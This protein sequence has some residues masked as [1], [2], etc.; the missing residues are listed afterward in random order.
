MSKEYLR[1]FEAQKKETDLRVNTDIERNRKTNVI[2]NF[3]GVENANITIKQKTH[4][5]NFGCNIFMLGEF[6]DKERNDIYS[7]EFKVLFNYVVTP[8]YWSD[9][10]PTQGSMRFTEES[11][12]IYRRPNPERVLKYC[13]ENGLRIKGHPLM[14]HSHMPSW[15]PNNRLK[16]MD[17][18]NIRLREI[19]ARLA[20]DIYDFDGVN[21]SLVSNY[22]HDYHLPEEYPYCVYKLIEKY[23]EN[24]RI[25]INDVTSISWARYLH[26]LS[27]YYMQIEN[28]LLK[29]ADIKGIGMQYHMFT[30]S[31]NLMKDAE[32]YYNPERLFRVMDTYSAFNLPLHVSEITVPAYSTDSDMEEIQALVTENLYKIWFSHKMM[33][34]IVWWNLADGTAY[35]ASIGTYEGENKYAGGL[36]NTSMRRKPVFKT[37]DKLI[38]SEWKTNIT[39]TNI[40]GSYE[41]RGFYGEYDVI[42]NVDGNEIKKTL[43]ISKDGAKAFNI[44]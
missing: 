34:G 41:F 33:D 14:W 8:L 12:A 29:G 23:F 3:K 38:N 9:F 36:L 19:A 44:N 15:A 24:N 39:E 2:L 4:E 20:D 31:E 35:G 13:K 17:C 32:I 18:L 7:E 10:E 26:T 6:P 43:N 21:E 16:I 42:L 37:L 5:F 27:P 25:F 11:P 40:S 30:S 28:L 1:F 22:L